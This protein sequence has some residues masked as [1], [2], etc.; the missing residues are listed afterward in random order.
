MKTLNCQEIV[1]KEEG[2]IGMVNG[3]DY[4]SIILCIF[5]INLFIDKKCISPYARG[6]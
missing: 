6:C 1:S 5:C 3:V 2:R 4:K